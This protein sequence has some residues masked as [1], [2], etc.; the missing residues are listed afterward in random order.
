MNNRSN[1]I[2]EK[3]SDGSTS[4]SSQSRRTAKASDIVMFSVFILFI[5]GFS[6]AALIT[7]DREFSE[8]ENRNLAQKPEFSFKN[9]KEGKFTG[10]LESYIS[11][12]MF[13]K[14]ALVSLK[15]DCDRAAL[16][17][18]LNGI[19]FAND[20]YLI[21]QYT[22]DM[23]QIKENIGYI[24]DWAEN[25]NCPVDFL[26]IPNAVSVLNEK[27][28]ASAVND[29][30][31]GSMAAIAQLL[32][33][34]INLYTPFQQLKALSD[35][36]IQAFYR[37]DHHWTSEGAKA[38]YDWYMQTSGQAVPIVDYNIE[39]IEDFYGTLYSKAP[40]AFI[41]PDKMHLY[42]NPNGKYTIERISEGTASDTLYDRSFLGKKDKY[43][44]F[45]GGNFAQVKIGTN[46]QSKEK[47]LVLKDSYANAFMP[48]LCDSYSEITMIDLRYYH[49][50]ENTVSELIEKNGIDRVILLY[51]MDFIN[52]DQNFIWLS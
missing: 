31:L 21:Q 42:S 19:Y 15:T 7:S 38:V 10:D 9:L 25:T 23:D 32:S 34:K 18:G 33:P 22:Q 16:K 29:D 14:D 4:A 3:K 37:T 47:V 2:N 27:L 1:K 11:D 35:S 45:M 30:Q 20:G 24:N 5:F 40:S 49:F 13:L 26:L 44:A 12:Q 52:S 43:S 6:I 39:T 48:F 50:A 8:M 36:G 17:T 51:N 41:K 28:P 46:A